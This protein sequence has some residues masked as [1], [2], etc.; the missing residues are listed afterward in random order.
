MEPGLTLKVGSGWH[1]MAHT[2]GCRRGVRVREC[3][4]LAGFP[5]AIEGCHRAG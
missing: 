1:R 5:M 4:H 3:R 2:F